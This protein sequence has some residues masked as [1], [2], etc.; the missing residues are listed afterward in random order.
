MNPIDFPQR[1]LMLAEDQPEY[2]TLPIDL[3][4]VDTI[5]K[6]GNVQ[7]DVPWEATACFELRLSKEEIA[8][9]IASGKVAIWYRQSLFG[10]PFQPMFISTKNP[11]LPENK[12]HWPAE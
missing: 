3:K 2:Q 9:I 7:K 10:S 1:N 8:A 12:Q 4:K 11:Y 6:E 5:D